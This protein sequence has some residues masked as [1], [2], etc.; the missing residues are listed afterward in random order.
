MSRSSHSPEPGEEKMDNWRQFQGSELGALMGSIY[1]ADKPKVRYP[2]PAQRKKAPP[3]SEPFLPGGARAGASDPRKATRVDKKVSV[4]AVGRGGGG[5][6][7]GGR[8]FSRVDFIPH[9]RSEGASKAEIDDIVM[10]QQHFRPAHVK[11]VSTDAEKE[12]YSQICTYKGGKGL[13][14]EMIHPQGEAPFERAQK[15]QEADRMRQAREKHALKRGILPSAPA[16]SAPVLSHHENLATQISAEIQERC[17]YLD[18]MTAM[19]ASAAD[20]A[21]VRGEISK[22][23]AELK[24]IEK[25]I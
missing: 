4:P 24:V 22:R 17:D 5:G 9:R 10:R 23:V 21:T 11:A 25:R 2:K 1:G 19:G 7:G 13:P 8:A 18:E 16:R 6:G 15:K 20:M 14:A 3:P 12:K